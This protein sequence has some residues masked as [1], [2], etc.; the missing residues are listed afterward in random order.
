MFVVSVAMAAVVVGATAVVVPWQVR[1]LRATHVPAGP[2]G[3]AV[4][5]GS[6][7]D[8]RRAGTISSGAVRSRA[9]AAVP[10]ASVG[11][12]GGPVGHLAGPGPAVTREL[13]FARPGCTPR[14]VASPPKGLCSTDPFGFAMDADSDPAAE[15]EGLYVAEPE[16]AVA[17]LGVGPAG[18]AALEAGGVVVGRPLP[19]G[20]SRVWAFWQIHRYRGY[21]P[22]WAGASRVRELTVTVDPGLGGADPPRPPDLGLGEVPQRVRPLVVMTPATVYRLGTHVRWTEAVVTPALGAVTH[23][24]ERNLRAGLLASGVDDLRVERGPEVGGS[25]WFE[26]VVLGLAGLAV[27]PAAAL[28][29]RRLR[30]R[31]VREGSAARPWLVVGVALAGAAAGLVGVVL[32]AE[33]AVRLTEMA[34]TEPGLAGRV[35]PAGL[36]SLPLL[37]TTVPA[38][39]A[40]IAAIVA[41]A[42]P[43]APTEP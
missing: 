16:T 38:I 2:P 29:G 12:V 18:R 37:L 17:A 30:R 35:G 8:P 34:V 9:R 33:A 19:G 40:V 25:R 39:V 24:Q 20:S 36:E 41:S 6:F 28:A 27:A 21:A 15:A 14:R 43:A 31:G 7:G 4:A 11:F 32:G 23:E 42:V 3:S 1:T 13:T 26:V 5:S 10:G 22:S